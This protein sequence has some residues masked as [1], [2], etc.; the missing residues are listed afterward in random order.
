MFSPLDAITFRDPE[1]R[2]TV[3]ES[4]G[5]TGPDAR[6][7]KASTTSSSSGEV[8]YIV[9]YFAEVVYTLYAKYV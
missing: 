7:L 9:S 8:R 5:A 2:S 3:A 4:A 1:R 6:R